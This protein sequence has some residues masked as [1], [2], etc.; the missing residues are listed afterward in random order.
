M[1]EFWDFDE[2]KNY[3]DINIHGRDYK[4][5]KKF[6]N[7]YMAAVYLNCIYNIIALMCK[8]LK[9]NS[10][11]LKYKETDR[12][13]IM[14][15]LKIHPYN[16]RLSEMQ[17]GNQ[18]NGINKPRGIEYTNETPLGPDGKLRAKWRHIFITLR[19]PNGQFKTDKSI[20]NLVIHELAHSLANHVR[21]RDD[22]HKK[23]FQKAEEILKEAYAASKEI[24]TLEQCI[25]LSL[26]SV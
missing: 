16:Y 22:D 14:C 19:T 2:H 5:I 23:D 24:L 25:I 20:M 17:L 13:M 11:N 7:P 8:Y 1:K 18:F 6:P 3:I 10:H 4:V 26:K 9:V 15:F 21:W 12:T